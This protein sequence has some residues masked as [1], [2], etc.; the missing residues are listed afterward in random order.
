M[1]KSG[2]TVAADGVEDD[3]EAAML[4]SAG[5]AVYPLIPSLRSCQ[6]RNQLSDCSNEARCNRDRGAARLR[7]HACQR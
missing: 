6:A 7:T 4:V 1:L 3:I 2:L 5:E